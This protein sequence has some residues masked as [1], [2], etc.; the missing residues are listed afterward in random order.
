MW[1]LSV[2]W[3]CWEADTV[4]IP[5][6]STPFSKV[7]SVI[8]VSER[9][10]PHS[11]RMLQI[12]YPLVAAAVIAL[13]LAPLPSSAFV[14]LNRALHSRSKPLRVGS[15]HSHSAPN[16]MDLVVVQV[17]VQ[18]DF[19]RYGELLREKI[20]DS[21]IVRWYVSSI[22]DNV[23]TIEAVIENAGVGMSSAAGAPSQA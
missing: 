10:I 14:A 19:A 23:A 12:L 21:K 9:G 8:G 16:N 2:C 3:C 15:L 1:T 18:Q 11:A 17:P 4:P 20:D 5:E 13:L 6:R 22:C 7:A